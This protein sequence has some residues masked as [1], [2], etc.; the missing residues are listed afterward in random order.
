MHPV[1]LTAAIWMI[2]RVAEQ[3]ILCSFGEAQFIEV[4]TY[5]PLPDNVTFPVYFNKYIIQQTFVG[6]TFFVGIF[7]AQN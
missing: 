7:V 3:N 5:M 6:D 4:V 1:S 2:V